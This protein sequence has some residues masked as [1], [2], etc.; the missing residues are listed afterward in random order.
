MGLPSNT[1]IPHKLRKPSLFFPPG[2]VPLEYGE[3]SPSEPRGLPKESARSKSQQGSPLYLLALKGG[4][5]RAALSYSVEGKVVHYVDLDHTA[6]EVPLDRVD[7][8]VSAELN[9]RRGAPFQL[10]PDE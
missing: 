10:P 5:I 4:V 8:A 2:P 6:K 7:R 9:R 3:R 1:P